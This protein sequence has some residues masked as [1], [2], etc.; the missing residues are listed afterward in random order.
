VIEGMRTQLVL[1]IEGCSLY[2]MPVNQY[3]AMFQT[4][5]QIEQAFPCFYYLSV[6]VVLGIEFRSFLYE[7]STTIFSHFIL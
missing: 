1:L 5:Y 2:E 7:V 6:F 3:N 4:F